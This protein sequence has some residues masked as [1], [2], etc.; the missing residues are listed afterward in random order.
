MKIAVLMVILVG[1][2]VARAASLEADNLRCEYRT[3]PRGLDVTQPRLSWLLKSGERGQL[4][5]A[6]QV[7]VA[8][9][10]K[11]LKDDTGDLW[12]S[13]VVKEDDTIAIAYHGKPLTSGQSCFWKVKV[14]DRDGKASD[15]SKP[16]L[17]TMGLLKPEDWKAEWIGFDKP[18]AIELPEAQLD[19]AKWIWHAAD[20]KSAPKC[21]RLFVSDFVLPDNIVVDKADLVIAADDTGKFVVN[22][23]QVVSVNGWKPAQ[24]V[25]IRNRIKPGKN[26][27]RCEVTN[28]KQGPAGLIAKITVT[29]TDG[30]T[31]THLTDASWKTAANPGANWHKR[32]L[33]VAAWPAARELGAHGIE[34]WGK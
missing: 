4:Q 20:P 31:F 26:S 17:W 28:S 25:D 6:Y 29:S 2:T 8:S 9:S 13:G 34:P 32:D 19:A 33:D 30:R 16:T 21:Q 27:L 11:L 14:W 24:I 1:A 3:D 18:H 10:A 7:L 23:A 22:S 15:W 12:D 5:A